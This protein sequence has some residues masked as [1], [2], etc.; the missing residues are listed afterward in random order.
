MKNGTQLN[1]SQ[2][3]LGHTGPKGQD[4]ILFVDE[5]ISWK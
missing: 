4:W 5:S 1:F 2:S 3:G